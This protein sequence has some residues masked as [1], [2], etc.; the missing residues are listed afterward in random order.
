MSTIHADVE[1]LEEA[2]R[3]SWDSITQ[4]KINSLVRSFA[5]RVKKMLERGGQDCQIKAGYLCC[6]LLTDLGTYLLHI[7]FSGSKK[8]KALDKKKD[9]KCFLQQAY[10]TSTSPNRARSG[11]APCA[12]RS[13]T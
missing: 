3:A 12:H 11:G 9:P 1:E 6:N 2:V 8:S 13:S 5:E 10:G 7:V 4:D